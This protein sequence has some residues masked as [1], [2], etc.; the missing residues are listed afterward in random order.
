MRI[1]FGFAA[2]L[3]LSIPSIALALSEG[4]PVNPG[5]YDAVG[6]V[7]GCSGTLRIHPQ[8]SQPTW[9][10]NDF[11]VLDLDVPAYTVAPGVQAIPLQNPSALPRLGET[12]CIKPRP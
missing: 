3:I 8:Y 5:Q 7:N 11:A 12:L 1:L 2:F 10:L 4:T 6:R 9:N